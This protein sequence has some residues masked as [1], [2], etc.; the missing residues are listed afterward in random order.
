MNDLVNRETSKHNPLPTG[1]ICGRLFTT[2]VRWA[3]KEGE[4]KITE[5]VRGRST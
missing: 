5:E 3:D 2:G 1:M 4:K